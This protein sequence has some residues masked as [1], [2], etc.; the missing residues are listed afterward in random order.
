MRA[1]KK[2]V[3][4]ATGATMLGATIMGAMAADLA[5]YPA[6][7]V[8]GCNF[9]GA[10]VVGEKA[11]S[12]DVVGAI[13]VSNTLAVSGTTTAAAVAEEVTVTGEAYKVERSTNRLN[14]GEDIADVATKIDKDDLPT[15][16]ADGTYTN[17]ES[18]DFDYE[19]TIDLSSADFTVISDSDLNEKDPTIGIRYADDADVLVYELEFTTD[20]ESDV[21]DDDGNAGGE[22]LEDFEDTSIVIL[23]NTYD[24]VEATNVSGGY[25]EIMGGAIKDVMEQ[26]QVKTFTISGKDYEVE[27]TYIGGT[28]SQVKLKVNGEVTKA[29]EEGD[30]YKLDDGTQIGIREI[31][32]EEAGEVTADQ[33]EF[34]IGAEKLTLED[35]KELEVNDDDVDDI[36]VDVVGATDASDE[37][38]L[39]KIRLNWTTDDEFFMTEGDDALM[40]GL[41]SIKISYEGLTTEAEETI[42]IENDG[43]YIIELTAPVKGGKI[44]LGIIN[45][46]QA[47]NAG[48]ATIG[49]EDDVLMTRA[50]AGTYNFSKD[51]NN[52]MVITNTDSY[53][54]HFIKAVS[55]D[56]DD[57]VDFEDEVTG[58][59]Y[60]KKS[61]GDTFEIADMTFTVDG[62]NKATK[63]VEITTADTD[64]RGD[65]IYTPEG[66]VIILP[67]TAGNINLTA[68]Y[69]IVFN[70]EGDDDDV[71]GRSF[72]VTVEH[73]S[74]NEVDVAS[75][76][77]TDKGEIGDTDEYEHWVLAGE[78]NTKG[79]K[80]AGPDQHTFTITYFG[81]E[82]YGNLYV[83]E[84]EAGF[85]VAAPVEGEVICKVT[86]PAA[87]LDSEALAADPTM[88]TKN[89]LL[90]G[91]PC[92]SEAAAKVMGVAGTIPE[93]L[94]GFEEGKAMI[95]LY[96]TGAGKVAM[97]VAGMTALDT[98]RACRVLKN[99][100]DYALS[101]D[102][103]EVTGTTLADISV[104]TVA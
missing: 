66:L 40:P 15:V 41:E 18:K 24:I 51:D 14:L 32:E 47:D 89:Y 68:G 64:F 30:T 56:D 98:R 70:E 96:D 8:V 72:K 93:C 82:T 59:E 65:R 104:S 79:I 94:A 27:V 9:Y 58:A 34:Y 91:G 36:V 11:A 81:G 1:I 33:V 10:I 12:E 45:D 44:T 80:D 6:P 35:G 62:F 3:A 54:T 31:L 49:D 71:D 38:T 95:K 25:L 77:M 46:T 99:Y 22:N 19:Q 69:D 55:F 29:L 7:F 103:V 76:N 21:V 61:D 48:T 28:P 75:S 101:G 87:L 39:S 60:N 92:A 17:D 97:L 42:E 100:K 85:G 84:S 73:N 67:I 74:D 13:D 50:G 78:V 88:S 63:R 16:L 37:Y 2:I 4:L 23:G 83:A 20:A 5:D 43:E 90:V 26:G 102:E 86:V 52:Y 53:E 57:G